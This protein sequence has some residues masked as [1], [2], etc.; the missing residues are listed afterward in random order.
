MVL[1]TPDPRHHAGMVGT[2]EQ[3]EGKPK[4]VF[5]EVKRLAAVQENPD[6]EET[7]FQSQC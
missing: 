7:L 6:Q 5:G 1:V 3:N 4:E 2:L